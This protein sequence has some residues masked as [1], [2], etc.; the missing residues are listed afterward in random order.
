MTWARAFCSRN[1][2]ATIPTSAS[3]APKTNAKIN[4]NLASSFISCSSDEHRET[5]ERDHAAVPTRVG[6]PRLRLSERENRKR[7][8]RDHVG[9]ADADGLVAGARGRQS[10]DEDRVR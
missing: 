10:T 3:P 2:W 8:E 1:R 4:V 9:R 6:H 7:A 5:S